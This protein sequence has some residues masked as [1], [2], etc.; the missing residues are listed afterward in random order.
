MQGSVGTRRTGGRGLPAAAPG[1]AS[2][3]LGGG[4]V[5]RAADVDV[6]QA[7]ERR[8][9]RRLTRLAV[10]LWVTTLTVWWRVLTGGSLNP[11]DGL[12]LGP[13][14]MLWLPAVL[15]VVL[16]AVVMVV[17]MLG[18]G[19]SPH[20]T[21]RPEQID[22]GLDDVKGIDAVKEDVVRSLNLFLG[23]TTFARPDG[24]HAAARP[25]LRGP[26]RHRQDPHGQGDGPRGR[27]AV[28]VRVGDAFQSMYYGATARKIRSYF[29]ALRKAAR[30]EG[31]AIGFIEEIDAIAMAAAGCACRA[32]VAPATQ[33]SAALAASCDGV[34]PASSH[35]LLIQRRPVVRSARAPAA[36]STS[37]S[38]RCSRSTTG[39][40]RLRG[41]LVDRSTR[42]CR[43][44]PARR[45][46]VHQHP[47]HR[48]HQP[49]RRPRPRAAA[50]RPL[51]PP[52]HFDLP[53]PGGPARAHRLLPGQQGART[54]AGHATS[55]RDRAGRASP[56]AT[57]R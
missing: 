48:G 29:K 11:L 56:T 10:V 32:A 25:A 14:A 39:G 26:A 15:I 34:P 8:R 40:E 19:R 43:P 24:R 33:P 46:P 2:A 12:R 57:R 38:S 9:Q 51:R 16:I 7:R 30:A 18:Q 4:S 54:R 23:Y 5:L 28:P 53:A 31:G 37:C 55:M 50:A 52:A 3:M 41:W 35:E 1:S 21:Y 6:G 20:V 17:P 47:A 13:D 44:P 36:S 45:P 42:S 49:R 27:R 22:V